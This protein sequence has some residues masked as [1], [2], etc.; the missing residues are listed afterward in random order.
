MPGYNVRVADEREK[1]TYQDYLCLTCN[2]L[3]KRPVQVLDGFRVCESCLPIEDT[4]EHVT[5][6]YVNT[7]CY[8]AIFRL[9]LNASIIYG[10]IGWIHGLNLQPSRGFRWLW[11]GLVS[12]LAKF[13]RTIR[14]GEGKSPSLFQIFYNEYCIVSK[15]LPSFHNLLSSPYC[16]FIVLFVKLINPF[17]QQMKT[18]IKPQG[19]HSME[20]F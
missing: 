19:M 15:L 11:L 4:T 18:E 5:A 7:L 6:R 1:G 17:S 9:G 10:L 14:L 12:I 2:L 3:L 16:V 20:Y 8:Y 13:R